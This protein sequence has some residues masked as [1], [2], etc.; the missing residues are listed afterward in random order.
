MT[1]EAVGNAPV[2]REKTRSERVCGGASAAVLKGLVYAAATLTFAV[3]LPV[4]VTQGEICC[5]RRCRIRKPTSC[6]CLT[7]YRPGR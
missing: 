5:V 3:L 6:R 2:S 4:P 1:R 7:R